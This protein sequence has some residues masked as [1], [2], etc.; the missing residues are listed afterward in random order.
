METFASTFSHFSRLPKELRLRIWY[1]AL[2][3][4]TI[5]Q[6]WDNK[7]MHWEFATE[8]PSILQSCYEPRAAFIRS[9]DS[10]ANTLVYLKCIDVRPFYFCKLDTIY[11]RRQCWLELP[12]DQVTTYRDLVHNVELKTL[13]DHLQSLQMDWDMEPYWWLGS[14]QQGATLLRSFPRLKIFTLMIRIPKSGQ[15]NGKQETMLMGMVKRY[16]IAVVE[17]E[18]SRYPEWRVP[19]IRFHWKKDKIDWAVHSVAE[20]LLPENRSD[21]RHLYSWGNE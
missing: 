10:D 3:V 2:P 13:S 21:T 14:Q 15:E 1:L 18:R 9:A 5:E 11:V 19:K 16:T 20:S 8:V 4:R 7:K 6:V 17:I 12:L